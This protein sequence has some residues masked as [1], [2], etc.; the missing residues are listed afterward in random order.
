MSVPVGN[1][2]E[3]AQAIL[4]AM[5]AGSP[6]PEGAAAA[7]LSAIG[8]STPLAEVLPLVRTFQPMIRGADWLG[9]VTANGLSL[10]GLTVEE[11][12]ALELGSAGV[13]SVVEGDP[14]L[15]EYRRRVSEHADW[16]ADEC[17]LVRRFETLVGA[18]HE[19]VEAVVRA[20]GT[21]TTG[22]NGFADLPSQ[23]QAS[24]PAA[25]TP[26]ERHEYLAFFHGLFRAVG[27][28]ARSH[29]DVLRLCGR[30]LGRL[31]PAESDH[32]MG[33]YGFRQARLLLED[34]LA[35]RPDD[36]DTLA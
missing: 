34:H 20:V 31:F 35:T 3:A 32:R 19:G 2:D 7:L 6:L 13:P 1:T 33:P 28:A 27:P 14:L 8:P 29:P 26:P 18:D 30:E 11:A 4:G 22:S 9:Y 36:V 25:Q 24:L 21:P 12:E 10:D 5:T 15:D 16:V 17:P 23:L